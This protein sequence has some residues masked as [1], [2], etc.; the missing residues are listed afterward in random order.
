MD[1]T[2]PAAG[3]PRFW[4]I[5]PAI[6]EEARIGSGALARHSRVGGQEGQLEH[7]QER[8]G[9]G[10]AD[11]ATEKKRQWA[12]TVFKFRTSA[13]GG[14]DESSVRGTRMG[15]GARGRA[16]VGHSREKDLMDMQAA[17][18]GGRTLVVTPGSQ[19]GGQAGQFK[20][21]GPGRGGQDKSDLQG[22]VG[23]PAGARAALAS[24]L[25]DTQ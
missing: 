5:R 14:P 20:I 19:A 23:G 6:G 9:A 17:P 10:P 15:A 11:V 2:E 18:R 3:S 4:P 16:P 22:Y 8:L 7:G 12:S 25:D 13:A 1:F 24:L 21:R